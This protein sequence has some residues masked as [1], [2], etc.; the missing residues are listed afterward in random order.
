MLGSR[1][2]ASLTLFLATLA[3][4]PTTLG[5][6]GDGAPTD[7]GVDEGVLDASQDVGVDAGP[8]DTGVDTGPVDAGPPATCVPALHRIKPVCPERDCDPT[9]EAVDIAACTLECEAGDPQDCTWSCPT[10]TCTCAATSGPET[11]TY[12][13]PTCNAVCEPPRCG[14][15]CESG[16][17]VEDGCP[18][19]E[20]TCGQAACATTCDGVSEC[21]DVFQCRRIDATCTTTC[22]TPSCAWVNLD[23]VDDAGVPTTDAGA[24]GLGTGGRPQAIEGA[25]GSL[26]EADAGAGNWGVV[27]ER[28][29]CEI[30][31][32]SGPYVECQ[33]AE[34]ELDC[35]NPT[36]T[37]SCETPTCLPG[38]GGVDCGTPT[39]CVVDCACRVGICTET[40]D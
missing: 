21:A 7:A 18:S 8:M 12:P 5:C 38:D 16:Q 23:D 28:P 32:S 25:M 19:C 24:C 27:C 40:R 26:C 39:N 34:C 10:P 35:E 33:T 6:G 1:P 36:C 2:H 37:V 14:T 30:R 11:C 29:E 3:L 9:C 13:G 15:T 22:N 4:A 17:C 20:A 31:C